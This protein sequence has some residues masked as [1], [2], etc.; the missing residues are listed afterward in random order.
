MAAFKTPDDDGILTPA[1]KDVITGE[2]AESTYCWT[3][4]SGIAAAAASDA[5]KICI[6]G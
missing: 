4:E 2:Y 3:K 1:R 6:I 5:I